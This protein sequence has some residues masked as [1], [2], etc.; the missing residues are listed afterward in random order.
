MPVLL[1]DPPV[2]DLTDHEARGGLAGLR[3]AY[4]LGPGATIQEVRLSGLRGRG[5]AGFPTGL[6]WQSVRDAVDLDDEDGGA[7]RAF[8]VCNGAEGEPATFKDR[9]IIRANPYA[10]VEGVAIAALAVGA[11]RAFIGIKERFTAE[12]ERL[13]AR[14]RRVHGGRSARPHRV[15]VVLGPDHYLYGEETGLLQVIEGEAPLPRN[16]PPYIHGLFATVPAAGWSPSAGG[17]ATEFAASNPTVVNNVETLATVP[18]VLALGPEWHRSLGT[19]RSPGVVV[20][21]VV[22]DVVRPGV[23]EVELGTPLREVIDRV[24][25]GVPPGHTIKAVLSGTA[26][27]VITA[28][29]LDVP[30]SYEGF[31]AIGSGMGAAGFWVL[32]DTTSMVEVAQVVSRFLAVESCGQCPACKLGCLAVTDGLDRLVAGEAVPEDVE[33]VAYRLRTVTDG[34]R[35][36]LPVQEQRVVGSIVTAFADEVNA[37][38]DGPPLPAAGWWSQ[39]GRP[40]RGVATYDDR[41]PP[42]AARL[43]LP[44]RLQ[45]RRSGPAGGGHAPGGRDRGQQGPGLV[46]AL[47]VLVL[48]HRVGHDAGAGL[49]RGP[50]VVVDDHRADG[51]GGVDVAREVE[52]ADHAGVG[53]ALGRLEVVD[54]LHGPHLGRARHRAGRQRGPQ[55]VDRRAP[56]GQLARHLR[57]EVH[58]VAVALERHHLVDLLGAE[59]HDPA[60]VVAGEVDQHHVLGDLLGVLAQLGGQAAVL[61]VGAAP[62]AGAG[63]GREMTRPSS[64]CTIGS[65]DDPTSVTLGLAHE[66]HVRAGV[67]LAQHPVEVERLGV[68]VEVEALGQHHLEDVAG[69]DVLLGDLDRPAVQVGCPSST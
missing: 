48:G 40:G 44:G 56:V 31:E 25:G 45:R 57:R 12:A 34:N 41:Q 29:Q 11:E 2:A 38:L 7:D 24:G 60:H 18:L 13:A 3:R 26:N 14:G 15:Q 46:A 32:D 17:V 47:E 64:S 35:C 33:T 52:V 39:A 66:V 5:G 36:Y 9:A 21:T 8:V 6:K 49:H 22:G 1:A 37:A 10:V 43:D 68:E 53:P 27:P 58:H 61:L 30:L 55:H 51:D 19:D 4:E 69:E 63:D 59:A 16:V 62:A 65:G 67:D 42:Q 50:A 28:D 23:G 20:A 54:D